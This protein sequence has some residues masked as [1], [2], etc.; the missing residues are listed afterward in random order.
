MSKMKMIAIVKTQGK[1]H[2]AVS[3]MKLANQYEKRLRPLTICM[4]L[5]PF[6]FS[7]TMLL[8]VAAGIREN[9]IPAIIQIKIALADPALLSSLCVTGNG[10]LVTLKTKSGSPIALLSVASYRNWGKKTVASWLVELTKV[11]S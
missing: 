6:S 2:F 5:R 1:K 11:A 4:C 9:P 7:F 10:E 3:N 8:T